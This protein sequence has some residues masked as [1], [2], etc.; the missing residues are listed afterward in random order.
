MKRKF[1]F[2][3]LIS[4][5]TGSLAC[6][7]IMGIP[8]TAENSS[9]PPT[10]EETLSAPETTE[11]IEASKKSL[12][13]LVYETYSE[14]TNQVA[15]WQIG[16][17]GESSILLDISEECFSEYGSR[18]RVSFSPD[19]MQMVYSNAYD[20]GAWLADFRQ[21]KVSQLMQGEP[22]VVIDWMGSTAPYTLLTLGRTPVMGGSS[23]SLKTIC[24]DDFSVQLLGDNTFSEWALSPDNHTLALDAFHDP[25]LYHLESGNLEPFDLGEYGVKTTGI[26]H[27]AWSPDGSKLAWSIGS[28][29]EVSVGVFDLEKKTVQQFHPY[30][31][32]F[33]ADGYWPSAPAW[34]PD[35]Q[36]LTFYVYDRNTEKEG[37]WVAHI[38]GQTEYQIDLNGDAVWHPNGQ[39]LAYET[40]TSDK[41]EL[42]VQ[43]PDGTGTSHLDTATYYDAEAWDGQYIK[44]WSPDGEYFLFDGEEDGTA[45]VTKVGAWE[46]LETN[47]KLSPDFIWSP[48]GRYIVFSGD[49]GAMQVAKVGIWEGLTTNITLSQGFASFEQ[50]LPLIDTGITRVAIPTPTEEKPPFSCPSAPPTRLTVGDIAR[51]TFTDGTSTRLR[52]EPESGNNQVASLGEGAE[53][54]IIGGPVCSERPGRNDAY[55]YWEVTV[56]ANGLTGW[57]AEGDFEDYYIEP[58]SACKG[59]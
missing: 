19:G 16:V 36:W 4:L 57:V 53:F 6:Q 5:L 8:D 35:G 20:G 27:P 3:L 9:L 38:N 23:G 41:A 47:I 22:I 52:S 32:G 12:A 54:E 45:K 34:S 15:L 14:T 24:L 33:L 26:R 58:W 21:G 44:I 40:N 48:D 51:V 30:T 31:P 42:W 43:Y 55:I 18:C 13:G 37:H 56:F 11:S 25:W 39:W 2:F 59:C 46:V 29:D 49:D 50:W 17:N 1:K 10:T 7:F 28:I